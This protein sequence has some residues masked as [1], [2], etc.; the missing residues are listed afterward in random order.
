MYFMARKFIIIEDDS[1]FSQ[2][3]NS[4]LQ[5]FS[6]GL[7]L[8][9]ERDKEKSCF[10]IF[11]ELIKAEKNRDRL[12]SDEIAFNAHLSRASV[13]HHIERLENAGLIKAKRNRYFLAK[14]N[15]GELTIVIKKDI[16][17]I[18]K[19]LEKTARKLDKEIG[20]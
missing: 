19:N 14:S 18:F 16:D 6:Q 20:L 8:F 17:N 11:V 12:S 15:L 3:L 1:E 9:S 13:I 7:G 4:M 10:R 5:C 2:D